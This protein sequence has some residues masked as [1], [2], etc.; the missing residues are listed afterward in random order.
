MSSDLRLPCLANNP[1]YAVQF[2]QMPAGMSPKFFVLM[3]TPVIA[4]VSGLLLGFFSWVA[5][6]ILRKAPQPVHGN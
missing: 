4:V 5:A 6:K 2:N 3:L 1:E